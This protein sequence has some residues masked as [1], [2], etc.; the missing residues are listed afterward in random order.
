MP[1]GLVITKGVL[2]DDGEDVVG[3]EAGHENLLVRL[4]Y[5]DPV[6]LHALDEELILSESG[7][8]D[9]RDHLVGLLEGDPPLGTEDLDCTKDLRERDRGHTKFRVE[10]VL[11]LFVGHS[12]L[13]LLVYHQMDP[14]HGRLI[15]CRSVAALIFSS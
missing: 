13:L 3:V 1:V 7:G 4:V 9:Q 2:R 14:M 8:E 10:N 12:F 5:L 6:P 15:I 11:E